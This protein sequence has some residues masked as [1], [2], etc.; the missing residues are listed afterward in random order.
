MSYLRRLGTGSCVRSAS[1]PQQR[2]QDGQEKGGRLARSGLGA[3]HEVPLG[4]D[5]WD[6]GLL[7]GG[8]LG[9][10]ALLDVLQQE[11][12]ESGLVEGGDTGHR[13][14]TRALYLQKARGSGGIE[15]RDALTHTPLHGNKSSIKRSKKHVFPLGSVLKNRSM[16]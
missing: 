4:E 9:V 15:A 8:R 13:V 3:S 5:D 16:I 11:S 10:A 6:G 1:L 2:M 7:N 14:V 12:S